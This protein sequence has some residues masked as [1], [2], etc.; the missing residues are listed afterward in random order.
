NYEHAMND[1][2]LVS[3]VIS[4][5]NYCH[6]LADAIDSALAQTWANTEVVVVDDGSTDGSRQVIARYDARVKAI[7]KK[8]GGMGSAQNEGFLASRGDIVVFLDA[9][10]T[11]ASTAAARCVPLFCEPEVV[12]VHWPIWESDATATNRI[13]VIPQ[14]PLPEGNLRS[15]LIVQG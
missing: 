11:L 8:N 7:F 6:F 12:K 10:D 14:H 13:R 15:H 4:N 2:P 5:H 1:G 9:D 3:I